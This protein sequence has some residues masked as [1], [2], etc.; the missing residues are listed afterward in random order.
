MPWSPADRRRTQRRRMALLSRQPA[1]AVPPMGDAHTVAAL[2]RA[3]GRSAAAVD[4][5]ATHQRVHE[6][7]N[8]W[9][10]ITGPAQAPPRGP[11]APPQPGRTPAG[12]TDRAAGRATRPRAATGGAGR[13]VR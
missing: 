6:G 5:D 7:A 1:G 4:P 9:A 10:R 13:P 3:E 12:S 8:H 11:Q 2:E